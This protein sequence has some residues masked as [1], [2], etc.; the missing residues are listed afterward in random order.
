MLG[1]SVRLWSSSGSFCLFYTK[2]ENQL[3]HNT[4]SDTR[5]AGVL[6]LSVRLWSD[7]GSCCLVFDTATDSVVDTLLA[8]LEHHDG[9]GRPPH[10]LLKVGKGVEV[11]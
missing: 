4:V 10:K 1:L 11:L 6:G 8:V 5:M 9:V 3:Y 2:T 7:S